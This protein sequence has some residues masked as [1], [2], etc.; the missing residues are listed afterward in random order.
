MLHRF[1][2]DCRD[3][4]SNC[5][6][7]WDNPACRKS[8]DAVTRSGHD[9]ILTSS[10]AVDIVVLITSGSCSLIHHQSHVVVTVVVVVVVG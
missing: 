6:I 5:Y 7:T 9:Q 3:D 2:F 1:N 8:I 4:Q 10:F